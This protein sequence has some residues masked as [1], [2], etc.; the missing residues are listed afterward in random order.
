MNIL[1]R[2]SLILIL[3][4]LIC[5]SAWGGEFIQ[6]DSKQSITEFAKSV[7]PEGAEL[8][9][10][11]VE[12]SLK[13]PSN[14][15][16]AIYR[17]KSQATNFSG[18]VLIPGDKA[19]EYRETHLPPMKE[20]DGIFDIAVKSVFAAKTKSTNNK[21]LVVL[22]GYYRLGSAGE[23]GSAGYF[24]TLDDNTWKIDDSLSEKLESVKNAQQAKAKLK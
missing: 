10:P 11:V 9:H 14:I 2:K 21:G 20:A 1:H 8:I 17:D 4:T 3:L 6:R 13:E 12:V 18:L 23:N 7:L 16:V 15:I 5:F 24:Y 19:L 22:Y